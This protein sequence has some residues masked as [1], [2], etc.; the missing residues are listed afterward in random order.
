M[1]CPG[2]V[3]NKGKALGML[4]RGADAA[5]VFLD[6]IESSRKIAPGTFTKAYASLHNFTA[7]HVAD[8][9]AA[10]QYL[11]LVQGDASSKYAYHQT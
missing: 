3:F 2:A 5:N 1:R 8:M 7:A 4:G 11:Q 6:A 9:E 10:M